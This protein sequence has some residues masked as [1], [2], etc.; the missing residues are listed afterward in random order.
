MRKDSLD[1]LLCPGCG[2]GGLRA[3]TS[4]PELHFGPLTCRSCG[5]TYAVVDGVADFL[6]DVAPRTFVG[7][8]RENG[9][10][11]RYYESAWR[12]RVAKQLGAP[13]PDVDSEY[14]LY[15]SLL[16][17]RPL[18]P[19]LD[20]DCG[21]GIFARRLA[22]E[23]AHGPTFAMDPSR[24]MLEEG[25]AQAR[26]H[27]LPIDFIRAQGPALPFRSNVLG[28]VLH[29]HG[30]SAVADLARFLSEVTRV[31]A[32]RARYV[33]TA[34]TARRFQPAFR[35]SGGQVHTERELRVAIAAAG[36]TRFERIQIDD[37]LVFKAEKP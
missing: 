19:L 21:T 11:A 24:A 15:K 8:L 30:V 17:A 14:L 22:Q 34:V 25:T 23:R 37:T 31:L 35:L 36:L 26:E 10:F 2:K 5:A 13:A 9:V 3:E 20:L 18:Q 32:P 7:R 29:G 27:Q 28:G 1:L 4:I 33:A 16:A 6:L 12:P